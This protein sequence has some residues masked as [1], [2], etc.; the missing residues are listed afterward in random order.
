M[1]RPPRP[2]TDRNA[3]EPESPN[4]LRINRRIRVPR[5]LVIDEEGGKLGEFMTEDAIRLA[6]ER[7][8]DLVEVAPTARPPVCRITDYGKL[9]YDKKKREQEARRNQVQVVQ[10]EIKLRPKT[11]EHDLG[12]KT[13][14]ARAF[15]DEGNKVK[16]TVRFRGRELAHREIGAQQCQAFADALKEVGLV[17]TPPRMEGRQMFM[18]LAPTR[19]PSPNRP[20]RP[21]R[22][23]DEAAMAAVEAENAL[24][25]DDDDDDTGE[26][27][28]SVAEQP[29]E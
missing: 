18:M 4:D 15:L 9:K 24:D 10:K 29:A 12:V 28:A 8:L 2:A 23:E 22:A 27:P 7:G 19:K 14:A 17:E 11:E 26:E 13:R 20:V 25:D 21:R 6:E 16:V 5:V 3:R 1:R